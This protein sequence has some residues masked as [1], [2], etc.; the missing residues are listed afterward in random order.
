MEGL[1]VGI[2]VG[3]GAALASRVR[4]VRAGAALAALTGAAAGV[5][6]WL[7]GGRLMLG[8]LALVARDFPKSRLSVDHVGA[9]FGEP[10]FGPVTQLLSSALE[11]ALFSACLV[12]AM[13][14]AKRIF[15]AED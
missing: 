5:S 12:G 15:A 13:L 3:A 10:G 6:I 8:S 2:G 9:L 1:L 14:L 4:S 7:L 11:A